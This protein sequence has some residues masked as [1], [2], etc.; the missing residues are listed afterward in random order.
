MNPSQFLQQFQELESNN[1][2]VKIKSENKLLKYINFCLNHNQTKKIKFKTNHHH[3][4]PKCYFG[5]YSKLNNFSWNGTHLLHKDHYTA[6]YLLIEALDDF[7]MLYGFYRMNFQD[8]NPNKLIIEDLIPSEKFQHISEEAIRKMSE[9]R[10]GVL[11]SK[12][13]SK[14]IGE[15]QLGS[16][17]HRYGKKNSEAS[18]LKRSQTLSGNIN[19]PQKIVKCPHCNKEGGISVMKRWHFENCRG[20]EPNP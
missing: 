12:E 2:Q 14:K 19:G 20:I 1:S 15:A 4:L 9:T 5:D 10:K 11:K 13:W 16:K 6:H 8:V 17:N 3:I 18:N 7:K